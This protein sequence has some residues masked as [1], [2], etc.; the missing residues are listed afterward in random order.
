MTEYLNDTFKNAFR[1]FDTSLYDF[2]KLI[3]HGHETEVAS[4]D[5]KHFDAK[6]LPEGKFWTEELCDSI[7]KRNEYFK[8]MWSKFKQEKVDLIFFDPDDGLANNNDSVSPIE[9][10]DVL[11]SKKL[12]RDEVGTTLEKGFSVLIHQHFNRTTRGGLVAT[13]GVELARMTTTSTAY[14]FWTH[15]DVFFLVPHRNHLEKLQKG[16]GRVRASLWVADRRVKKR[17]ADGRVR[18]R[19]RYGYRQINVGE[20]NATNREK[21]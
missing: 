5:V 19:V 9:K 18:N 16:V 2:L 12:F 21:K 1:P 20:H 6:H 3:V 13:L 7:G 8:E 14:S 15:N 4:R 17:A 10:G 11:S